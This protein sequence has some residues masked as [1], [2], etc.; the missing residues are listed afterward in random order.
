MTIAPLCHFPPP[1]LSIRR[2]RPFRATTAVN[3]R[4]KIWLVLGRFS[5]SQPTVRRIISVIR[6]APIVLRLR[7][8]RT[9]NWDLLSFHLPATPLLASPNLSGPHLSSSYLAGPCLILLTTFPSSSQC[10]LIGQPLLMHFLV[11]MQLLSM[12]HILM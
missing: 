7:F 3:A 4:I 2:A 11:M 10:S 12:P 1:I 9:Y 5:A 8:R 6:T